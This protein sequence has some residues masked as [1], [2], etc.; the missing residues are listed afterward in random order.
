M[1]FELQAALTIEANHSFIA[2]VFNT[3]SP[4]NVPAGHSIDLTAVIAHYEKENAETELKR[5]ERLKWEAGESEAL[6][7]RQAAAREK[8]KSQ[9]IL[10]RLGLAEPN[11]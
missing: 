2:R 9:S 4:Y 1:D 10:Q 5:I 6:A 8:T 7:Q 11:S 3:G